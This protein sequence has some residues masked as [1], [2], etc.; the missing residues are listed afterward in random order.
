MSCT[1]AC[2]LFAARGCGCGRLWSRTGLVLVLVLDSE[3]GEGIIVELAV[4]GR[5]QSSVVPYSRGV[6]W[7]WLEEDGWKDGCG[8]A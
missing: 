7:G 4:D 3:L 8:G 6:R 2:L 5:R 1:F